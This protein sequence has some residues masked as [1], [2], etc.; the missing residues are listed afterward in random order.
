[1][2]HGYGVQ[3]TVGHCAT[4]GLKQCRAAMLTHALLLP[5]S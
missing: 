3:F 2:R 1:M 4:P 5:L